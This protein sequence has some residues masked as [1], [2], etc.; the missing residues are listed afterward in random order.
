MYYTTGQEAVTK[1]V[2]EKIIEA[3]KALIDRK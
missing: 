3:E 1:A 2:N